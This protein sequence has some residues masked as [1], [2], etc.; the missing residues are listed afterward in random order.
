MRVLVKKIHQEMRPTIVFITHDLTE[1]FVLADRIVVLE[2]GK[3]VEQ[4]TPEELRQSPK[5]DLLNHFLTSGYADLTND[6]RRTN[7]E[8]DN[9]QY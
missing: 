8:T 7:Y 5:S 4:G 2:G 3:I 9:S 6:A 1:A